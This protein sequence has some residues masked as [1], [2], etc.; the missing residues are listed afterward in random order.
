M[1]N[2]IISKEMVLNDFVFTR[3]CFVKELFEK[4]LEYNVITEEE[5][6]YMVKNI[7]FAI[8]ERLLEQVEDYA[9]DFEEIAEVMV[10]NY[11][12]LISRSLYQM[13]PAEALMY[14]K[15]NT[16]AKIILKAFKEFEHE[17]SAKY[18]EME[19]F[20]KSISGK[21]SAVYQKYA[22]EI[23]SHL[24][25]LIAFEN[26]LENGIDLT[27]LVIFSYDTLDSAIITSSYKVDA[28]LRQA[29]SYMLEYNIRKKIGFDTLKKFAALN[30]EKKN[31]K[32]IL[33]GI[34]ADRNEMEAKNIT[35]KIVRE[36]EEQRKDRAVR[37]ERKVSHAEY[38]E[39]YEREL[40]KLENYDLPELA[41]FEIESSLENIFLEFVCVILNLEEGISIPKDYFEKRELL[42]KQQK[43]KI[44]DMIFSHEEVFEFTDD[45]KEYL[46]K[47]LF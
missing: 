18:F 42:G 26:N 5:R 30:L 47:Y 3:N 39:I 38:I 41:D 6:E 40:A 37:S 23:M 28:V 21:G 12:Y 4:A 36:L 24:K 19:K 20:K 46:R 25:N 22:N 43:E 33:R 45:E 1:E 17:V 7:K 15:E 44:F 31:E 32:E 34:E 2:K 10:P 27:G 29:D 8:E 9:Y 14:L 13:L 35:E 11:M 16:G